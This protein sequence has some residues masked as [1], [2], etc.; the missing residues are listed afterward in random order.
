MCIYHT[1]FYF[2][3]VC[4]AIRDVPDGFHVSA[5]QIKLTTLERQL[6]DYSADESS[7][8]I[9]VYLTPQQISARS[10]RRQGDDSLNSSL[11]SRAHM[12]ETTVPSQLDRSGNQCI[13]N[14][15]SYIMCLDYRN[16]IC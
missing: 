7:R 15:S 8:D 12:S 16:A 6:R 9:R 5:N 10:P 2:G 4:T 11:S 13:Y 14:N 3:K 1:S